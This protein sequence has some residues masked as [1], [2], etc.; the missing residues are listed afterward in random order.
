MTGLPASSLDTR[1]LEALFVLRALRYSLIHWKAAQLYW[2][3]RRSTPCPPSVPESP[4]MKIRIQ[5]DSQFLGEYPI[6]ENPAL[7]QTGRVRETDLAAAEGSEDWVPVFQL[8]RL[9][10]SIEAQ[11]AMRQCEAFTPTALYTIVAINVVLFLLMIN[12]FGSR[13]F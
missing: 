3:C 10:Q 4:S 9:Q 8:E 12:A 6:E 5:R 1:V 11:R 7:L 2:A 13:S